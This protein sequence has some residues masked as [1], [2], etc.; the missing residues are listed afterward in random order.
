[1]ENKFLYGNFLYG[2]NTNIVIFCMGKY[3]VNFCMVIFCV[4][5]FVCENT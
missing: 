3:I 1:M 4:C 5:V 2:K